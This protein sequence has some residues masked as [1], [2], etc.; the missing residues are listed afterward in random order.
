[1]RLRGQLDH[2]RHQL[3]VGPSVSTVTQSPGR[4][5][6]TRNWSAEESTPTTVL[7][8]ARMVPK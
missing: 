3:E 7:A 5:R 8:L 2:P 6:A 1:V 4:L